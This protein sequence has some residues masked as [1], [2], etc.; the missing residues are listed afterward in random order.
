MKNKLLR[1]IG[2]FGLIASFGLP[3]LQAQVAN[4]DLCNAQTLI[5]GASCGGGTN[6]DNTGA[7][8]QI[9]EPFPSCLAG[10]GGSIESVWFSFTG[11][12]TGSVDIVIPFGAGSLFT[13][14]MAVY[15]FPSGAPCADLSQLQEL[16]CATSGFLPGDL[17][18]AGFPA[19]EDTVYYIQVVGAGFFGGGG[20]FCLELRTP[21][22]A[23][24]NDDIC[25]ARVLMLGDTCDPASPNGTNVGA[26]LETNEPAGS[27]TFGG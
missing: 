17:T 19:I 11:D 26:T 14:T 1:L 21:L 5:I 10:G 24:A 25:S 27:C 3:N 8:Q 6:G 22:P 9:N 12:S 18:I 4:D 15:S 7:T 2:L 23:P 20:D 16:A 13:P